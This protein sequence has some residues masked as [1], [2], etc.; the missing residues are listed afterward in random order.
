[1]DLSKRIEV[2]S[3][4]RL[5]KEAFWKSSALGQSLLRMRHLPFVANIHYDNSVGLPTLYN[6]AIEAQD[7]EDLV[8]F[9]HD[10]VWIDDYH[11]NIRLLEA[12]EQFDI[13]GV[14]GNRRVPPQHVGWAFLTSVNDVDDRKYLSGAVA[15]GDKPFAPI[16]AW[17]PPGSCELLDGVFIAV[18]RKRLIE[19]Q[20]R[21]DSQFAFHFY[22]LDFCRSARRAGLKIGT[23]PIALTHQSHGNYTS[24]GWT[25]AEA[26]YANKWRELGRVG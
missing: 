3:A 18:N 5:S 20:T 17:G 2:V 25:Q 16:D 26:K 15:H 12:F 1:M 9:V 8:V 19:T 6:A 22:D 10:D 21:F 4:T 24:E 23:W 7:C 11:L 13:V 14:A